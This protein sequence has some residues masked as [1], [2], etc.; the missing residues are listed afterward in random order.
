[1]LLGL[2]FTPAVFRLGRMVADRM[3]RGPLSGVMPAAIV[4]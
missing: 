3:H 2:F 1:M 4:R